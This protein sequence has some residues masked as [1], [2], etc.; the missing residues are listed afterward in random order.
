M[1]QGGNQNINVVDAWRALERAGKINANGATTSAIDLGIID[2]GFSDNSG[3][4]TDFPVH[5]VESDEWNQPN[6]SPCGGGGSCPWHGTNVALAAAARLDNSFGTAGPAGPVARVML[7]EKAF[8]SLG[9]TSVFELIDQGAEIINMSYGAR[10]PAIG[11]WIGAA[12]DFFT[13]V[14]DANDVLLFASAGND[15]ETVDGEDCFIFC[16]EEA[17]YSPCENSFVIC[18]GGLAD[19]SRDRHPNSNFGGENVDIYGP[20]CVYVGADPQSSSSANQRKCGTSFSSP[21]VAGVAALIWAANPSLDDD[22][23]RVILMTRAHQVTSFANGQTALL[24]KYVN[25][26]GAVRFALGN[27]P[28]RI[29]IDAPADNS[30]FLYAT[31]KTYKATV[32]DLDSFTKPS[33]TWAS[34]LDGTLGTGSEITTHFTSPGTRTITATATD[35]DGA[36]RTASIIVTGTNSNP[37]A[38]I[39]SPN[40][41]ATFYVNDPVPFSGEGLD[42]NGAFAGPMPCGSLSW[43]SSKAGD[44]DPL[45]TG[46]EKNNVVF[47]TTGTRTITLTATDAHGGTGTDTVTVNIVVKPPTGPPMVHISRPKEGAAFAASSKIRLDYTLSD[48]GGTPQSQYTVVWKLKGFSGGEKTITPQICTVQVGGFPIFFT[49]FVPADYGISNN[50]VKTGELSLSIT[51]PEGLTGTDKVNI[52]IGEVP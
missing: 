6:P 31:D 26:F 11:A 52:L 37:S 48:P 47:T 5:T 9:G 25:A 22:A 51:D 35:E 20:F 46:C 17:Y 33:V 50:G 29:V 41:N 45:F 16:W 2:G 34:S 36:K 32:D 28:P 15:G 43:K 13:A 8:I 14:A 1:K 4:N 23:V 12:F 18:V 30:S 42:G 10:F 24:R 40:N 21:F 3:L 7:E 38:Q 27:I 44:P 39:I 49:C 19:D